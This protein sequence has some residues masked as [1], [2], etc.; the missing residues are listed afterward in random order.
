MAQIFSLI[1]LISCIIGMSI[2]RNS[3]CDLMYFGAMLI[4]NALL[5]I[6]NSRR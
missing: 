4:V 6:S 2:N 1:A 3:I 5:F